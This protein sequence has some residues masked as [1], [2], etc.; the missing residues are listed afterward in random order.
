MFRNSVFDPEVGVRARGWIARG[1]LGKVALV[2]RLDA[3][4]MRGVLYNP[5]G[6]QRDFLG[7][8]FSALSQYTPAGIGGSR[9]SPS[10]IVCPFG[11]RGRSELAACPSPG[12]IH[13]AWMSSR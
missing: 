5:V 1:D 13:G 4:R 6:F 3:M 8:V 7:P 9:M 2:C 10:E 12:G 11:P